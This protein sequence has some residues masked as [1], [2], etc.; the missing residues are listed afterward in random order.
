MQTNTQVICNSF[1][2]SLSKY[3]SWKVSSIPLRGF[4][5]CVIFTRQLE[6]WSGEGAKKKKKNLFFRI[7]WASVSAMKGSFRYSA[8]TTAHLIFKPL[9][10]FCFSSPSS[11]SFGNNNDISIR[12]KLVKD[13][14]NKVMQSIPAL[15]SV[16]CLSKTIFETPMWI[17][18]HHAPHK[19][20]HYIFICNLVGRKNQYVWSSRCLV[21]TCECLDAGTCPVSQQ[22]PSQ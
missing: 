14:L 9:T 12:H 18:H 20:L 5:E 4:I 13:L 16:A 11:L 10:I 1:R 19:Y 8:F 22:Y 21:M 7:F 15:N 6:M 17:L 3:L 2:S